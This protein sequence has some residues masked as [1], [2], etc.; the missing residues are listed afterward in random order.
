VES[1]ALPRNSARTADFYERAL[2]PRVAALPIRDGQP[3]RRPKLH[4]GTITVVQR[5]SSDLRLNPHLHVIALD[6]V[7][8]EQPDGPPCF[9]QLPRLSSLDV[10]ELLATTRHR[11]LRLLTRRGVIDTTQEPTLLPDDKG[12]A[13]PALALLTAA[14]VSGRMP[15]GPE[16]RQRAPIRLATHTPAAITGPLCAT[17]SGF[18]LHAATVARRDDLRGQEALLRYV[19]RPALAQSRLQMLDNGLCRITLKRAFSDGT[20]AIDLDPLSLLCRLAAA[21]PAPGFNTVRYAGIL[22]P[23]ATW[24]PLVI[25]QPPT[26]S[27]TAQ[28]TT[29]QHPVDDEREHQKSDRPRRSRWRPWAELLKRSFDIELLCPRCHTPMKLKSFLTSEKSLQRLLSRLAEPTDVQGKAPARG[30]P[31]FASRVLRQR[32]GEHSTQLD[33]LD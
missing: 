9:V 27:D 4:S 20:F 25:P 2:R 31:Y 23:A 6:G 11:L 29:I 19:L 21:V 24:R 33:M 13:D 26:R 10:A 16:V 22:A 32:F 28:H 17:D 18:T 8:A 3:G 14:S 1:P 7:F 15:A 5:V 12:N 30:P